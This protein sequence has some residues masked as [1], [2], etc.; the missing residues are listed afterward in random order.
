MLRVCAYA[1]DTFKV[2]ACMI[3]PEDKNTPGGY[4]K[5]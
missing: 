1:G 2:T 3:G 4:A 5:T